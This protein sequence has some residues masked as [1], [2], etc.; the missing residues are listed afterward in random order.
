MNA[1]AFVL[2]TPCRCGMT[3]A[4]RET[5]GGM[6]WHEWG[7]FWWDGECSGGTGR[8]FVQ[9]G[10]RE[11]EHCPLYCIIV[12]ERAVD[13]DGGTGAKRNPETNQR[14]STAIPP[15]PT[16]TL[17]ASGSPTTLH[18]AMSAPTIIPHTITI[19]PIHT[20]TYYYTTSHQ[21]QLPS[22]T[23]S[24]SNPF[25]PSPTTIP[26]HTSINYHPTHHHNQTHSHHHL[27]L[28]HLTPASTTIPHT[29]TIK[30][31]HTITY[32]YTTSH[33]H[34]LPS[35]TPSQSN[36]FTPSPTTIPPHTSTIHLPP[37]FPPGHSHHH[38]REKLQT[39]QHP[40]STTS[41]SPH[42]ARLGNLELATLLPLSHSPTL[43]H[44]TITLII[45]TIIIIYIINV[46][47]L[48]S[49]AV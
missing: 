32:Y 44:F 15:N 18:L 3:E 14:A 20:I 29:I 19:K 10:V 40:A 43:T 17:P 16:P 34:Q 1:S 23:P 12:L 46:T 48:S 30:P 47:V 39:K 41:H 4:Q 9:K 7:V 8:V 5:N 36:P 35:H 33:Q 49:V 25:T 2:N 24:Q 11:M 38:Q 28:Y 42:D 45:I 6:G 31:I 27:L 21:H 13:R 26:P 37:H 22:H